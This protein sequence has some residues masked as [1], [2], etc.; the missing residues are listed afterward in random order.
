MAGAGEVV[1]AKIVRRQMAGGRAFA[2]ILHNGIG[3]IFD[4]RFHLETGS[5]AVVDGD[6]VAIDPLFR[7]RLQYEAAKAVQRPRHVSSYIEAGGVAAAVE[8][9]SGRIY[10]GVCVDTACTLGICAERNAI[11]NMM[12]NG[13]DAIRRVLTIMRDGR[14]GPPCGACREMMTQ[15]MPSRF[16]DIEVMIDFAAGKTMTLADLTPQW[17]LRR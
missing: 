13:E 1:G 7:Q 17:W 6:S 11:L 15:L 16:G 9:S 10:T 3:S 14:T 5:E 4:F 12:T 2:E 8:S